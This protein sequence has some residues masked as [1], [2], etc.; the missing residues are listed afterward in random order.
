MAEQ[1]DP[2]ARWDDAYALGDTSRSWFQ[3]EPALSLRML[4]AAG[5]SAADSLIDVGGGASTLADALLA[6]GFS[7]VTVL[8][9]SATGMQYARRRLGAAAR[10]VAW[11][12]ADVLTWRPG[13]RYQVWHDRAVFHFLTTSPARQ[14]YLRTLD[15][16]TGASA[17]AV[18]GCFALDGPEFC[19]GLPVA[20]YD[21]PGLASQL[22]GD[23]ALITSDTEEHV[24]PTGAVQ[25]F[26]WAAFRRHT[27]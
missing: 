19:S 20:R 24:T 14:Q 9:V 26:T 2:A 5:V 25:P 12:V 21:P 8:D 27:D 10:L 6:R 4:D 18:F 1:G 23:W 15:Q 11:V 13:R 7:D 16:A 3:R 17:V 22:G